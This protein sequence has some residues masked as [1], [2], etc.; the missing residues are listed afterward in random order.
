MKDEIGKG[1]DGQWGG[2]GSYHLCYDL[3]HRRLSSKLFSTAQVNRARPL[4][5]VNRAHP[6]VPGF[7]IPMANQTQSMDCP[8]INERVL[9]LRVTAAPPAQV[10]ITM[11]NRTRSMD[12]PLTKRRGSKLRATSES[13]PVVVTSGAAS[14]QENGTSVTSPEG[15]VVHPVASE[16]PRS[17]PTGSWMCFTTS[18]SK[19]TNTS[20]SYT[21]TLGARYLFILSGAMNGSRGTGSGA[22]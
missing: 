14:S 9:A 17:P 11:A 21:W 15:N 22:W 16:I 2:G 18:I 4:A 19:K 8:V 3:M 20:E 7:P 6:G 1:R 5:Q 10:P 13:A 12:Y